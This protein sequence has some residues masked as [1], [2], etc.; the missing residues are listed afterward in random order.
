[1][2][3]RRFVAPGDRSASTYI[4]FL[5]DI[6]CARVMRAYAGLQATPMSMNSVQSAAPHQ[7]QTAIQAFNGRQV[8]PTKRLVVKFADQKA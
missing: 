3:M 6:A 5:A 7:A 4:W 8:G 1:V 2:R